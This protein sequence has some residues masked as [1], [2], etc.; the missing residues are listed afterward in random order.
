MSVTPEQRL[1]LLERLR[2]LSDQHKSMCAA[3]V[4]DFDAY[5]ELVKKIDL[6]EKTLG[7]HQDD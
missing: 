2:D 4:V 7:I 3:E 6:V 5:R 1:I